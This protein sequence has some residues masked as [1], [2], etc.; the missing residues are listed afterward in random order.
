MGAVW[1]GG[2]GFRSEIEQTRKSLEK[3]LDGI[4]A[5]IPSVNNIESVEFL[6]ALR[7]RAQVGM[8]V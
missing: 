2:L 7:V 6:M 4:D 1:R 5:A 3:L 8:V